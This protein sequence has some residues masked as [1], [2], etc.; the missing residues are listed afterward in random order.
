MKIAGKI[1]DKEISLGLH[2]IK[3][4]NTVFYLLF[5]NASP[6]D[7]TQIQKQNKL[8]YQGLNFPVA[9]KPAMCKNN[10][11]I[12]F[13]VMICGQAQNAFL[14][15]SNNF[16]RI[17]KPELAWMLYN[18]TQD[19]GLL[20]RFPL[21][22]FLASWLCLGICWIWYLDPW[23][24]ECDTRINGICLPKGFWSIISR[25]TAVVNKSFIEPVL[26][27]KGVDRKGN[28][29]IDYRR[30]RSWEMFSCEYWVT[31][32]GILVFQLE[33]LQVLK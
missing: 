19:V 25:H 12:Y 31:Y 23:L 32:L 1:E 21:F 28:V 29:W 22:G 16:K 7:F 33:D 10:S 6:V 13:C 26:S 27:C 4:L 15:W 9:K 18:D 14:S 11:A 8:F 30:Q 5:G 17:L 24:P 2:M 3:S 20:P